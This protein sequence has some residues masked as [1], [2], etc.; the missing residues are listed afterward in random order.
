MIKCPRPPC[1][2]EE[3]FLL[4]L[5][6]LEILS[7][8]IIYFAY[9]RPH[10]R[11]LGQGRIFFKVFAPTILAVMVILAA[12]YFWICDHH[13]SWWFIF[14]AGSCMGL[15]FLWGFM[16]VMYI[17][18]RRIFHLANLRQFYGVFEPV[19]AV[20]CLIVTIVPF[21][22]GNIS[23]R[24]I[25]VVLPVNNWQGPPMKIVQLTDLHLGT[26]QG[27]AYLQQVV[28]QVNAINPDLVLITGDILDHQMKSPEMAHLLFPLH[29][30]QS[31]FGNFFVLGNHDSFSDVNALISNLRSYGVRTLLN[32]NVIIDQRL[33]LAGLG[34]PFAGR[35]GSH[36]G[37]AWDLIEPKID[38][39]FPVLL[40]AHRPNLQRKINHELVDV[41]L[42]GHTHGGQMFPFSILVYALNDFF[43]GLYSFHP[44]LPQTQSSHIKSIRQNLGQNVDWHP[45][46]KW[47]YVSQGT[48]SWG[49]P[50][51]LLSFREITIITLTK[52]NSE[53]K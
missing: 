51:R 8:I 34:E 6:V 16:A 38:Q 39:R 37:P 19:W 23:P 36:L 3:M 47:Y 29:D 11:H 12:S 48:G 21:I 2:G 33:N 14:L 5:I 27:R 30:L 44:R 45:E 41:M 26:I 43:K 31:K 24:W 18:F 32:E 1:R 53:S 25:K 42:M 13:F 35:W 50:M 17:V 4:M 40:M 52:G 20:L 22:Q 46:Y 7:A 9:V 49:P 15:L 10:L 28:D